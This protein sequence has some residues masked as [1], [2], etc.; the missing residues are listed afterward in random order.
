M[1]RQREIILLLLSIL[2]VTIAWIGF[3]LYHNVV[4][5]TISEPL[6][7]DISPIT[8]SFNT[9]IISLLK[10]RQFIQP[11]YTFS[12]SKPIQAATMSGSITPSIQASTSATR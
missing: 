2:I 8:P 3:N 12:L 11:Q 10:T 4:T 7:Q 1:K 9:S 5:S 6:Q